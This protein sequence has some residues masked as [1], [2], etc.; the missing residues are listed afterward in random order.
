M[1]GAVRPLSISPRETEIP[2]SLSTKNFAVNDGDPLF[3]TCDL[4]FPLSPE[5]QFSNA[6]WLIGLKGLTLPTRLINVDSSFKVFILARAQVSEIELSDATL[7]T[8][9]HVTDFLNLE[10]NNKSSYGAN[11]KFAVSNN[12]AT[13]KL[14]E[15]AGVSPFAISFSR[16]LATL[17]GFTTNGTI[18]ATDPPSPP[19]KATKFCD[20]FADFKLI[21]VK[22]GNAD[23]FSTSQQESEQV[24]EH[25]ETSIACVQICGN[26]PLDDSTGSAPVFLPTY[27]VS[28]YTVSIP[29]ESVV[30]YPISAQTLRSVNIKLLSQSSQVLKVDTS[31]PVVEIGRAHV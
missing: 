11:V 5:L 15:P 30:F 22:C 25:S 16:N 1:N 28:L 12:V 13:C 6:K 14:T 26:F 18:Y 21:D 24:E 10:I 8:V 31:Q 17:L 19:V 27:A 7:V 23:G 20:P 29:S 3:R 9:K 2:L 4:S